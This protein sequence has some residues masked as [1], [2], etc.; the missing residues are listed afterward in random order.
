MQG[1]LHLPWKSHTIIRDQGGKK[2][3]SGSC[4]RH[5]FKSLSVCHG[6]TVLRKTQ[7][8]RRTVSTAAGTFCLLGYVF[9]ES[10]ISLLPHSS[11]WKIPNAAALT[12]V[13][14]PAEF[15]WPWPQ[16]ST[17]CNG[18]TRILARAPAMLLVPSMGGSA[19]NPCAQVFFGRHGSAERE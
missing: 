4:H 3:L 2:T 5:F 10:R 9:G 17:G 1:L 15:P 14:L 12:P 11:C 16:W 13:L 19:A 6:T 7:N 8:A 18:K